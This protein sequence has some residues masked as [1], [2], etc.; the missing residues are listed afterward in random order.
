M[1]AETA[2][3]DKNLMAHPRLAEQAIAERKAMDIRDENHWVELV[4]ARGKNG[5]RLEVWECSQ[6]NSSPT[7]RKTRV[8]LLKILP[9]AKDG[10]HIVYLSVKS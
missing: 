5:R 4:V 1:S 7:Q 3:M 10:N 6:D 9:L 2:R 8:S